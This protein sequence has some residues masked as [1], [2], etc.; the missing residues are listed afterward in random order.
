MN[1]HDQEL[2]EK[3]LWGVSRSR[4]PNDG[5]ILGLALATVFLVGLSVGGVLFSPATHQLISQDGT[6]QIV[7]LGR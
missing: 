6:V 1:Q 7:D 3:Q 2:L 4:S 5:V